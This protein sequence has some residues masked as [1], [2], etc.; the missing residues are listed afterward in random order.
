[1]KYGVF[2][3]NEWIYPDTDVNLG[4]E[5]IS[6][7]AAENS[8]AA[9]QV[10]FVGHTENLEILWESKNLPCPEINRLIPAFV[11]KNTGER[12]FTVEQGTSV[13]YATR[14]AP[15]WVYDAM[16]EVG[17]FLKPDDSY[18]TALYLR[19]PTDTIPKGD[20]SGIL[21]IGS[22]TIEVSLKVYNVKIPEN[23]TLRLTNWYS[24][25]NMA[26][27][28][29]VE[30][31]SEKHWSLIEKYGRLMREAR[32]TD[33]IIQSS[34]FEYERTKEGYVFDFSK[35]ER[36]I[37][38]Y[39]SLGFTYI[40]GNSPIIR[41]TWEAKTFIVK[42]NNKNHTALSEEGLCFLESFF[43]SWYMF[44]N[45]N[46]WISITQQHVADEPHKDCAVEYQILAGKIKGWMPKVPIIEA[47]EIL[48]LSEIDVFVPKNN[49]YTEELKKIEKIRNSDKTIWYYTCCCPGGK[50]LNRLLDQELL[51]TRYLH[52]ANSLYD[53]KGYLHWGL[54]YYDCTDDPFGGRA[55][56]IESLNKT[57]LP[58]GDSHIVYPKADKVLRSVRLEMMRA[59][60]ED[61]ELLNILKVKDETK[62]NE[63][64][65][66]CVRSFTDYETD[67]SAFE[68][69]Y[70]RLLEEFE[71]YTI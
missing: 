61:F 5:K 39:L 59:G 58:C 45:K 6:I 8:V 66:M 4:K 9:A 37:K 56:V 21:Y 7:F 13:D 42:I 62:Y 1:M 18:V 49:T 70:K 15:F 65:K 32:Q 54:N 23:E 48:D 51:R 55:G 44:L 27:Y 57:P 41:E 43:K 10:L 25:E 68:N 16:D 12:G 38:L 3:A 50:Y 46:G 69:A 71:R 40:E 2:S 36:F 28:H 22:K 14:L 63:I 47:V 60:I 20:Y 24:L 30:P 19:W 64:M 26:E 33:F 31:W 53:I 17:D 67:T 29:G 35:A 34:L 11:E 52:W